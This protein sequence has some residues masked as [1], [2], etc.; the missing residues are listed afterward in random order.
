MNF[1]RLEIP[2]HIIIFFPES[3][4]FYNYENWQYL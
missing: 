4:E 1:Y 3:K 2:T